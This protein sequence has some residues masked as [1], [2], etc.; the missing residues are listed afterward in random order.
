MVMRF[1]SAKHDQHRTAAPEF[2][3]E[4]GLR[5]GINLAFDGKKSGKKKAMLAE[6][7]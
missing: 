7:A 5:M 3:R 6:Q 1:R 4:L 2:R